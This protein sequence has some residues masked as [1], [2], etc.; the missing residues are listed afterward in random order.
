M[1]V[2]ERERSEALARMRRRLSFLIRARP[3][4]RGTIKGTRIAIDALEQILLLQFTIKKGDKEN[5]QEKKS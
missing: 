3:E 4:Y 5:A 1:I 2:T